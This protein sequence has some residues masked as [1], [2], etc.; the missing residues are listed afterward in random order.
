MKHSFTTSTHPLPPHELLSCTLPSCALPSIVL[1]RCWRGSCAC[2]TAS[3]WMQQTGAGL[4]ATR[5]TGQALGVHQQQQA[6]QQQQR[7]VAPQ[8]PLLGACLLAATCR[9]AAIG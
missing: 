9:M 7:V 3:C 8:V 2:W 5:Q 6:Q 1:L 4:G